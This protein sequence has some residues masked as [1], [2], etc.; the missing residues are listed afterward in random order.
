MER[1]KFKPKHAFWEGFITMFVLGLGICVAISIESK[2]H[3]NPFSRDGLLI[4]FSVAWCAAIFGG[5]MAW[6][7][8]E[9]IREE[10]KDRTNELMREYLEK[11]L[12]EEEVN[13]K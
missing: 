2:N 12:R 1:K 8:K 10:E 13:G 5:S 7:R 4:L 9:K 6:A 3:L 11:K